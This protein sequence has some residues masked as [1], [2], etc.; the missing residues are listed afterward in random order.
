MVFDDIQDLLF[1]FQTLNFRIVINAQKRQKDTCFQIGQYY[2]FPFRLLSWLLYSQ[3]LGHCTLQPSLSVS[4]LKP[5]PLINLQGYIVIPF[6]LVRGD[7]QSYPYLCHLSVSS[8]GKMEYE[9]YRGFS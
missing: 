2:A 3:C 8:T 9:Q 7:N 1:S 5:N 6:S 4:H